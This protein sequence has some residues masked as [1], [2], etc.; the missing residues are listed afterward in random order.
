MKKFIKSF[1]EGRGVGTSMARGLFG[2][3]GIGIGIAF[4]FFALALALEL[5]NC[6]TDGYFQKMSAGPIPGAREN[7]LHSGYAGALGIFTI[8][9]WGIFFD[10]ATFFV[11]SGGPIGTVYGFASQKQI[12]DEE[13]QKR[14]E[15]SKKP[16]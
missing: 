15:K 9:D 11:I 3:V 4:S 8:W 6:F 13:K 1:F 14:D 5:L 10:V 16:I 12:R 7:L 2:G